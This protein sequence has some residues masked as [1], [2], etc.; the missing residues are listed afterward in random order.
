MN[1]QVAHNA[2]PKRSQNLFPLIRTKTNINAIAEMS[3]TKPKMPVRKRVEER[4]VKPAEARITGA[5]GRL[6]VLLKL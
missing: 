2:E 4:E 5:S 1:M 6:L 3:L